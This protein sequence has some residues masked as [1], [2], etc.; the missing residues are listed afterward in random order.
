MIVVNGNVF[1]GRHLFWEELIVFNE[2]HWTLEKYINDND[3]RIEIHITHFYLNSEFINQKYFTKY[4]SII[5]R[6]L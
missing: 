1:G 5:V 3:L 2:K 6:F 4:S